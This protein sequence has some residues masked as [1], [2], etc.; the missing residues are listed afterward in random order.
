MNEILN[1][2][3]KIREDVDILIK[4]VAEIIEKE[5]PKEKPTEEDIKA[6]KREEEIVDEEAVLKS[7]DVHN[8]G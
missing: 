2:I 7:L 5:L 6:I 3:K 8:K 4:M 1:E